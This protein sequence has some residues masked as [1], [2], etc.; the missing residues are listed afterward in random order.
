[1]SSPRGL[2]FAGLLEI[3][4]AGMT[5]AYGSAGEVPQILWGL[6]DD[7]PLVR[8]QA[9]D[10]FY[11]AVH[12]QGD[13]NECTV[14]CVP[15]LVEA[16]L[17]PVVPDR[18]YLLELLA[19]VCGFHN[20]QVSVWDDAEPDPYAHRANT[21]AARA[22]IAERWQSLTTLLREPDPA[23]RTHTP[24]ILVC[25]PELWPQTWRVLIEHHLSE[26]D[27]AVRCSA[28]EAVC[29]IGSHTQSSPTSPTKRWCG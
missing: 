6:V 15:F 4:W 14:A 21:A 19:S 3:D 29:A 24:G 9:L 2:R 16:V 8:E 26:T 5:H 28:I 1:M 13:V 20:G 23:V 12:H 18:G 27:R 7:D 22:L 11:G 10:A 17:D 25:C